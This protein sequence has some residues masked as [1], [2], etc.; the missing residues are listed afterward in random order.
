MREF[1]GL[2]LCASV[3]Q[4]SCAALLWACTALALVG[5]KE[6][7]YSKLAEADANEMLGVLLNAEITAAKK[8]PDGKTWTISVEG[9][10]LGEALLVLR[11]NGLPAQAHQSLGDVFKKDGLISTPTEERVRFIHGVSQEL[12]ATLTSI[13]GVITARVHVVLPNNDPLAKDVKPSSASVFIKH[14]PDVNVSTLTPVVKNLVMRSVEGLSYDNVNVTVVAAAPMEMAAR[15][16]VEKI[17]PVPVVW[18][19]ALALAGALLALLV[20]ALLRPAWFPPAWRERF[21][22]PRGASPDVR[23]P[24]S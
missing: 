5:C 2:K 17:R 15:H 16:R 23:K 14:R 22:K 18:V 11:A 7:L 3:R 8:S 4:S 12:A 19:L 13:D 20:T 1:T 10:Q 9:E 6:D 24:A 21:V